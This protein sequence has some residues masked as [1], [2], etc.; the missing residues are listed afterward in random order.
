V[1]DLA[2]L[3]LS[4]LG[5]LRNYIYARHGRAFAKKTYADCFSQFSWYRVDPAYRDGMLNAVE[6]VNIAAVIDQERINGLAGN[7]TAGTFKGAWF[8]I[9]VPPSF[10]TI[11][12]MK[13]STATAKYDSAVFRSPDGKVEFYIFS[14]QWKG[15]PSDIAIDP[16]REK[17]SFSRTETSRLRTVTWFPIEAK[18]G[19][20]TRTYQDTRSNDGSVRWVVGVKYSDQAAF[21]AYRDQYTNFKKSLRQFAD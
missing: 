13:S 10:T 9:A 3:T 12:S 4:Q 8:E 6:Q 20:Y 5:F 18:D 11:P 1:A 21:N 16:S 2:N 15:D 7:S 17:Q 19:S 14:P